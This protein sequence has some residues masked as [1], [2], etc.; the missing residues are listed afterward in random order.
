MAHQRGS[1]TMQHKYAQDEIQF[2]VSFSDISIEVRR[3]SFFEYYSNFSMVVTGAG[4]ILLKPHIQLI[5]D[6]GSA[7][8]PIAQAETLRLISC[9]FEIGFFE[10]RD[11]YTTKSTLKLN[12]EGFIEITEEEVTDLPSFEI[13]ITVGT[14]RKSVYAY[15]GFPKRLRAFF[16]LILR[17]TRVKDRMD[18]I[19]R[20]YDKII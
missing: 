19:K 9:A 18:E 4:D 15:F 17:V 13:A 7:L 3:N 14:L 2:P 10:M 8:A 12:S 16:D 5:D 6:T 11:Q 1:S 20:E